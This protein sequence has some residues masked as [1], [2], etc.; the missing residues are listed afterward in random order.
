MGRFDGKVFW[1]L[2]APLLLPKTTADSSPTAR[3]TATASRL[4]WVIS[5]FCGSCIVLRALA[6]RSNVITL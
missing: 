6:R 5:K 3:S 4:C 2:Q 1:M